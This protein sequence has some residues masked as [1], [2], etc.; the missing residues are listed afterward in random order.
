MQ[1]RLEKIPQ[2][3]LGELLRK[4]IAFL[5]AFYH[6]GVRSGIDP[7]VEAFGELT[8]RERDEIWEVGGRLLTLDEL[9]EVRNLIDSQQVDIGKPSKVD[10][11]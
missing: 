6:A 5:H 4:E 3:E 10:G 8:R 2:A 9:K 11:I 7:L 1:E